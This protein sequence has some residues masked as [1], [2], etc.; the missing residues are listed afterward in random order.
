[1]AVS[2]AVNSTGSIL[3]IMDEHQS[4]EHERLELERKEIALKRKRIA[5]EELKLDAEAQEV[6]RLA[7]QTAR[8]ADVVYLNVGGVHFD[9][10]RSTLLYGEEG[11]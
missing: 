4:V 5:L 6:S 11:G 2:R 9:T 8:S 3:V 7:N 1:M 10:T